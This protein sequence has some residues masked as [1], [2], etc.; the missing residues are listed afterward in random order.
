M[1]TLL[2][3]IACLCLFAAL[4]FVN[5]CRGAS[6]GAAPVTPPSPCQIA[7]ATHAGDLA[8]D[9]DIRRLQENVQTSRAGGRVNATVTGRLEQLGW[10]YVDKARQS[11][12]AGY[13]R[14]AEQC[15]L[16]LTSLAKAPASE[17]IIREAGQQ[18]MLL[19]GH[20]LHSLHRFPEAETLAREL[21]TRRGLHFDHGLLGDVL[22][23]QGKLDEAG[24][25]YQ[26]M[27]ELKPGP[28][29][30]SRAAHLFWLRGDLTQARRLMRMAATSAPG[31][32]EAAAWMLTR[33]AQLEWQGGNQPGAENALRDALALTRDYAPA[34]LLQARIRLAAGKPGAAIDALR[35]AA[36]QN[37]LPEY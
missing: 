14:L 26:R 17:Q 32:G 8:I 30:Y 29:A 28:Q 31:N 10:K 37:P 13:Y 33:Y 21:T 19:R 11:Y 2:Q 1:K 27:M 20:V 34:L 22:L 18:S 9:N 25:A 3:Q 12:D 24:A 6:A 36:K 7:L 4:P 16:C 15:A 35:L 5:G 23:E